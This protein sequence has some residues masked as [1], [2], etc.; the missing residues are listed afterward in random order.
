MFNW[1][2]YSAVCIIYLADSSGVGDFE[3]DPWF[4]RGWTLQELLAPIE[5]KFYTKDWKSIRSISDCPNDKDNNGILRAVSKT[6]GIK[7]HD[8]RPFSPGLLNVRE[9]MVWAS[10]RHTTLEEDETPLAVFGWGHN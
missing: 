7:D 10:K 3:D 9:K 5:I 2:R 8:L 6:T 1:Y 4:T